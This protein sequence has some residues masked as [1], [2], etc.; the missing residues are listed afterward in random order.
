MVFIFLGYD[1]T[2]SGL[3]KKRF[4]SFYDNGDLPFTKGFGKLTLN[5]QKNIETTLQCKWT[6]KLILTLLDTFIKFITARRLYEDIF[7]KMLDDF[8][9]DGDDTQQ[10]DDKFRRLHSQYPNNFFTI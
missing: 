3:L 2:K 5:K 1:V 4:S 7:E 9:S 8:L 6:Y 10:L